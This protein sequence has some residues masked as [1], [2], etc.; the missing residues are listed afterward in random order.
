[1]NFRR[2]S[3]TAGALVVF[4]SAAAAEDVMQASPDSGNLANVIQYRQSGSKGPWIWPASFDAVVAASK[5][6]KVLFENDRVRVLEVTVFAHAN[7]NVHTHANPSVF[8]R[9]VDCKVDLRYWDGKGH[10]LFDTRVAKESPPYQIA[11]WSPGPEPPH[12]VENLSDSSCTFYRVELKH[13][14][15][16][17]TIGL[18][19][20]SLDG[21][22][23][24]PKNHKVILENEYVRVLELSG[25]P[26]EKERVHVHPWPSVYIQTSPRFDFLVHGDNGV[27]FDSRTVQAVCPCV[28]WDDPFG[29]HWIENLSDTSWHGYRVELKQ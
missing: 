5:N 10:V 25:D 11:S 15:T 12:A 27:I 9:P 29:P 23:A 16:A 3:L 4:A 24:A 21:P 28:H 20:A 6:H 2:L 1:M 17:A 7:E 19:P 8:I 13:L 18:W 22:T 26:H 14:T